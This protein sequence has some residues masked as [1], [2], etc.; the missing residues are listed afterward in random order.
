[1][2]RETKEEFEKLW[3]VVNNAML[4]Q[5]LGYNILCGEDKE[6]GLTEH[7]ASWLIKKLDDPDKGDTII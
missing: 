4:V 3:K 5:T 7:N 6:A 1:M 2:D